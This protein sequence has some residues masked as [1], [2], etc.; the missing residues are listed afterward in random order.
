MPVRPRIPKA[1]I[2]NPNIK[3]G[4]LLK[5]TETTVPTNR[6]QRENLAPQVHL[7]HGR[8]L[9]QDH[10]ASTGPEGLAPVAG[11]DEGFIASAPYE[12]TP[13][14]H[15][16][17]C[18]QQLARWSE[19][20]S[21]AQKAYMELLR[22]TNDLRDVPP[23]RIRSARCSCCTNARELKIDV[24][25]FDKFETVR[26][27]ASDCNLAISQLIQSGLFPCA[28]KQPT[29]A[30]DVRMLD[31]VSRL[32]LR[33]SPNHTAWCS[34][35]EDF[36]RCQGYRLQGKDPLQ[37]RFGNALQWFSSLK[38]QNDVFIKSLLSKTRTQLRSEL[39]PLSES[40]AQTRSLRTQRV[41]VEDVEDEESP[42]LQAPNHAD[43]DFDLEFTSGDTSHLRPKR[44]RSE[45]DDSSKNQ[46]PTIPPLS[47]PSEYLRARCP[48]CFGGH[49]NP[50]KKRLEFSDII[51][52]LDANF[53]Q[54]HNTRNRDPAR[55]HPD[56]FFIPEAEVAEV[57]R[58]VDAAREKCTRPGKRSRTTQDPEDDRMEHGMRVSKAVL[59]LCG[60]SFTAAHEFLAKVVTASCDVTGLMALL[61]RHDR[62]LFVVNMDTPGER[63]HYAI[64]LMEKLFEHLPDFVNVGLLYNIGCQL[65][66][67]CL[68][69]GL[70]TDYLARL[71]F[72]ISVF[73]AFGHQ[74]PC[75]IIYHPRKCIGFGLSD[76]E[77][78]ECLWHSIQRLIAYTRVAGYHLRLYTLDSQFHFGN[79]ENLLRMG[80]WI[81]RKLRLS[82]EKRAEN[83]NVLAESR[84]DVKFLRKQWAH[85][86]HV[87][88][89]PLPAQSKTKGK[90]A[91]QECIRLR[92]AQKTLK[93]KMDMFQNI[94]QNECAAQH[95]I[96][97]AEIELPKAIE[98]YS[99]I[100][101]KV[102]K[103]EL[104]LGVD[105]KTQLYRMVNNEFILKSMNARALKSRIGRRIVDRKWEL[106]RFE[107]MNRH[108]RNTKKLDTHTENAV[109]RRDP[110]IQELVRKYNR[111]VA[112]LRDLHA[113]K[114]C[115][116]KAV[117]P[118]LIDIKDLFSLDV[119]D[120][121]W[122]DIGLNSNEEDDSTGPPPWMAD[123]NVRKGIRA[124]LEIDRCDEEDER[125]AIEM[126]AMKEWFTE[127]WEVLMKTIEA[128]GDVDI[129]HQLDLWRKRL[130][131]LCVVW[132]DALV[133]FAG[134]WMKDWGPS[135][136]EL[137][138]ARAMEED[139][140]VEGAD[141]EQGLDVDFE[142]E[143]DPVV[144][145]HE[146]TVALTEA[147]R[148]NYPEDV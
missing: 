112:E 25:Q 131:Q 49:F 133:E 62:P 27:W 102:R 115:P 81:R 68:K 72:A 34:A 41:T 77:G 6:S 98:D 51:V 124:M 74:W 95:E 61:C 106:D 21:G 113:L 93:K 24:V 71:T 35:V 2:S 108:K 126:R 10:A 80:H 140:F 8:A 59:D 26:L 127:E 121:F 48:I 117:V 64:A 104:L 33:V 16:R 97:D 84:K 3:S 128:T 1:N 129:Q 18:E 38:A 111:L 55:R 17:K 136:F 63:Q 14:R 39:S 31:F 22:I 119:D 23:M 138:D 110:G 83:Q 7:G 90:Q 143:I 114:K 75:Q 65:E 109:K 30:V 56:T 15:Y 9:F 142:S 139:A 28:P 82:E 100:S 37:R 92:G 91:V 4:P 57:E 116:H 130:N 73:H 11:T 125:L 122:Q 13:S 42:N 87:Q 94:L 53:T 67:S 101:E 134:E 43:T 120:A 147:Y 144:T 141:E 47:C 46:H 86:V 135:E 145:E 66:R 69:W 54:R 19:V 78:A 99:K 103:K 36:L 85:Q 88:T 44:S 50:E 12:P 60:G 76:G 79:E 5:V 32:F 58:R 40:P 52:C 20:L 29:L 89:Q 146:E 137:A 148:T 123:D 45:R 107:R 96:A 105:E 118:D 70:L 132:Q